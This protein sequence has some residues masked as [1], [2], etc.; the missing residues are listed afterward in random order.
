MSLQRRWYERK[1][2][3]ALW[4]LFPLH[5][6]FVA[7]AS[8]RRAGYRLGLLRQQ[9]LPVPVIVVGN[10]IVGGAGKTP[11]TL[12]LAQAL[13]AQG[14][15]PGIISRGHGSAARQPRPVLP[16]AAAP[17]VGDEPLLLQQRSGVPVWVGRDRAATGAALLAAHP[18]VDVL[19]S[20]DG[21][22]HYR[23][24]RDA[25]IAVFDPRAAGNGWRLPLGPLREPLQRLRAVTA[26]VCN[27]EVTDIDWP[28]AVPRFTMRLQPA[29]LFG[30]GQRQNQCDPAALQGKP[31][32]AIAGIGDPARF[33]ATVRAMGL[34]VSEHPF[35]DHHNYTA[36]DL[37]FGPEAVLLMTEKDAVKCLGLTRSDAWVVPVAAELP[38]ALLECLLEKIDGR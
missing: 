20:D 38:D 35:P 36:A 13:Q 5:S 24:A 3:P 27:G 16:G 10:L 21:L 11:L 2:S 18:D 7:L 22:Q 17:E 29:G 12:W 15:H 28:P 4:P 8:V 37:D 6:L 1:L 14:R 26:I 30:L 34:A 9:R 32:H 19:I 25:E 23:L 33:F 31:L